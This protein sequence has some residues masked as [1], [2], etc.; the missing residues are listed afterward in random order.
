MQD[1]HC[2]CALVK[3]FFRE[4][5]SSLIN[6]EAANILRDATV[7]AEGNSDSRRALDYFRRAL[8]KLPRAN[9]R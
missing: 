2:V 3:L 4:L 6:D 7:A 1:S 9:Y 5:P 8:Y